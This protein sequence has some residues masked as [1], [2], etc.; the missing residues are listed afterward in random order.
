MPV[1]LSMISMMPDFRV[2]VEH[3]DSTFLNCAPGNTHT[4]TRSASTPWNQPC[5]LPA[6]RPLK[7]CGGRGAG[8]D[9]S[10][11]SQEGQPADGAKDELHPRK[12]SQSPPTSLA[13]PLIAFERAHCV[14]ISRV[15]LRW[16]SHM[17]HTMVSESS[18]FLCVT[19][20]EC[21]RTVS[22]E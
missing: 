5:G 7:H 12:V 1:I 16:D 19:D 21:K 17:L 8:A 10:S 6:P 15:T 2:V 4:C 20:L 14:L 9:G 11:R 18:I 13:S 3:C 22:R